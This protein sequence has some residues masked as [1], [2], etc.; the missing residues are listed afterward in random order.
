MAVV[1]AAEMRRESMPSTRL[2]E[3]RKQV[4]GAPPVVPVH[5]CPIV[6][7]GRRG[8]AVHRDLRR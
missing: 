4:R 6:K 8:A 5:I 2:L 1:S 3:Q 7:V